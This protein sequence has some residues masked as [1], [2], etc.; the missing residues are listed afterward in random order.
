MKIEE[1]IKLYTV[2]ITDLNQNNWKVVEVSDIEEI[3]KEY[4]YRQ[5]QSQKKTEWLPF[6]KENYKKFTDLTRDGKLLKKFDD[7][8]VIKQGDKEPFAICTHFSEI[9]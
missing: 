4:Y 9:L 1:I 6:V 7:G 8:S 3:C 2:N 5:L